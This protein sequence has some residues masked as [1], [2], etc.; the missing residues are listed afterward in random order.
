MS[1]SPESVALQTLDIA[2]QRRAALSEILPGAI[3]DGVLDVTRLSGALGLDATGIADGTDRYG[4]MWAGQSEAIRTLL[5]PGHVALSPHP[6]QPP[7]FDHARNV[8]IEGDNLEVLKAMQKAYNDKAKLIYIDPPY[9][10]G[11]DF[12]YDDDFTDALSSYL[13]QTGQVDDTGLR[14]SATTDSDGRLHSRWLTMML[15]RLALARNLLTQDG[16]LLVSINDR[17]VH[18]LRHLMDRTFG[19]ENFIATFLWNNEGN[20]EQQSAFKVNHEYILAYARD[21]R[22]VARPT[23]IDP[24][25]GEDS[26]LFN[27]E[28]E[29]S[30]TKNGPKN[31][32]S[33]VVL[34][35]GFP[36]RAETLSLQPRDDAYPK[37]LDPIRVED[38][39]LVSPARVRSGWS[40]RRMLELY[41]D[42]GF[43]AIQ[44]GEGKETRFAL[45]ATG[46]IYGYKSRSDQQGHVL[47]VLRNLGTTKSASSRMQR[48]WGVHFDFPKPE[49]LL[50]YLVRMFTKRDDLILDFFAGSGTTAE[51]VMR[52]NLDDGA[53]RRFVLVQLPENPRDGHPGNLADRCLTRILGAMALVDAESRLLDRPSANSVRAF[54][55]DASAFRVGSQEDSPPFLGAE[56]TL[57]DEA[58][59]DAIATE[60]LLNEGVELG[61]PWERGDLPDGTTFVSAGGITVSLARKATQEGVD[62]LLARE[63]RVAVFLEDSFANRDNVKAAAFYTCRQA[64]ISMKTV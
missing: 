1:E 29:N 37:I 38:G 26:K 7:G 23:I 35:V 3:D 9:N 56:L 33:T 18:N 64:G 2:A 32:E 5:Q 60:I 43:T 42:N 40:S 22:L 21:I 30:I 20:I 17:E 14:V 25:I 28:I 16:V 4:L 55:Q 34:P 47:T 13:R 59:D 48:L 52:A 41:I 10:T 36:C 12:V 11:S 51:A 49:G 27:Q 58:S 39:R 62:A 46:A 50:K 54:R 19:S 15:P 53:S 45:T 61:E 57:V 8:F 44:D 31:P 6:S 24:N 63:P